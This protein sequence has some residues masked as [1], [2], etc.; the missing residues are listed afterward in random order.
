MKKIPLMGFTRQLAEELNHA[1][2]QFA[3]L[4]TEHARL[5]EQLAAMTAE[6]DE[7]RSYFRETCIQLLGHLDQGSHD[8]AENILRNWLWENEDKQDERYAEN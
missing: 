5:R 4:Q 6:R 1:S 7:L 3:A 8:A 2:V